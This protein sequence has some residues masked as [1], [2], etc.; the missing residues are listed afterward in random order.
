MIVERGE[1]E[2]HATIEGNG[3]VIRI[4][5][6]DHGNYPPVSADYAESMVKG[7]FNRHWFHHVD[8]YHPFSDADRDLRF[9]EPSESPNV[10]EFVYDML[11]WWHRH[12]HLL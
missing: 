8:E 6:P 11:E 10:E 4:A 12:Q 7:T 1:Y 2:Y 3:E 5:G 9:I